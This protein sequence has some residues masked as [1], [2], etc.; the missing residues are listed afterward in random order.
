MK[1]NLDKR[2]LSHF[3]AFSAN[4]NSGGKEHNIQGRLDLVWVTGSRA[5]L[6]NGW[7][8]VLNMQIIHF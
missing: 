2:K 1:E 8:N 7:N 4:L 5:P 3:T 6:P